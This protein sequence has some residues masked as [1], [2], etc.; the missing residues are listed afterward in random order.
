[1]GKYL[2]I[3]ANEGNKWGGSEPLWSSAAEKLV[4]Q[5]GNEVRVSVKNWGE[6]VPQI[7]RLRE[8]GCKI[9]YRENGIPPFFTRQIRRIF[10]APE[11]R[12]RHVQEAAEDAD[13]VV[14]SQ[15]ANWD[16]L[17][18][19]EAAREAGLPYA[20]ISQ[21]A[22]PYWWPDDD[23]AKRLAASY[24]N[25]RASYF[26]SQANLELSRRQFASALVNAK[27][28][29]NPFNVRYE[30][31]LPWPEQAGDDLRL[32][33]V[34]RLNVISKAQD[35]LLEVLALPHW[36]ERDVRLSLVGA[37]PNERGLRYI[38]KQLQLRN[39]EF[40][41]SKED[42]EQVWREHHALALPSRFEGMPLVVV[43]AMLCGRPCIVTDVGGNREL[44]RDGINGFLAKAAT[45]ELV[46]EAMNRAWESRHRLKEIGCVAAQDVRAWVSPD[47]GKDFA[48]E[49]AALANSGGQ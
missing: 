47:P 19:I 42:M 28:V 23:T 30:A 25:A 34:G 18:W 45:V 14:I 37:G 26:V 35:V 4:H 12:F 41:G 7:E 2:F 8:A 20:I 33:C 11:Y 32:A 39:V 40:A 13:L 6:P 10:P 15:G 1:M 29:R 38:A 49:L 22:V 36:R 44:I 3:M 9:L 48:Q 5:G 24:E 17:E 21:S 43:E 27:V 16:G 46:D 31:M